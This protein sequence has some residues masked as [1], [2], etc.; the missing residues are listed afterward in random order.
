MAGSNGIRVK[1]PAGEKSTD[2]TGAPVGV[3]RMEPDKAYAGISAIL[4]RYIN[5][6]DTNAWQE[7]TERINYI[8]ENITIILDGLNEETGFGSNVQSIVRI[9]KKILFKPNLVSPANIDAHTHGEGMGSCACTEWA[10]VAAVMRWFHD[11]LNITYHQMMLGEAASAMSTMRGFYNLHYFPDNALTNE[12]V[13]EGR[14]GDFYGGWGFYFVRKYLAEAHETSH[15]D[16][17]LNGYEE[18]IAGKYIAPGKTNDRLMV[19]DLNR[20]YDDVSKGRTV[21]VPG[22]VNYQ[23]ITI[24]K[25][26][27][28]GDP[29]D[30]DDMEYNID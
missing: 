8:Y 30:K 25:V 21:T 15:N 4:Q 12:A 6:A 20:L 2:D 27:I 14:S 23:E 19:Y 10:F 29:D 16:N 22:G 26:I 5:E 18:S 13:M 24:H 1:T 11:R 3:V 17:P 7:I 28:G 9:G